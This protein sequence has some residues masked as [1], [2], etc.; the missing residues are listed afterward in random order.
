ML[1]NFLHNFKGEAYKKDYVIQRKIY[2]TSFARIYKAKSKQD[3]S[4]AAVKIL[5]EIGECL[6]RKLDENSTT[7]WEGELLSTLDHLNIVQCLSYD[8]GKKYWIVM[9][10]LDIMLPHYVLKNDNISEDEI[11]EIF[12]D[13]A[14]ALEYLHDQNLVYGDLSPDNIMLKDGSVKLIDF[15]LTLPKNLDII[16]GLMGTPSYMSPEMIRYREMTQ[17]NDI[18][19]FGVIMYEVVTGVKLFSGQMKEKRMTLVLNSNPL[20][21][22]KLNN[23]CNNKLENLILR[24]ISKIPYE[25]P[26][27]MSEVKQ[28]LM[29]IAG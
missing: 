15:G 12:I 29:A 7:L 9:E 27:S 21:P 22:T 14:K 11:L 24:C 20:K 18:Y 23:K 8:S 13:I 10:Y 16:R 6:A 3:G 28:T 19:S 26:R 1:K 5:N 4:P 17:L 25:R 2:E